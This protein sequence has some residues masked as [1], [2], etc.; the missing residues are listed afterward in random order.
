M[1]ITRELKTIENFTTENRHIHRPLHG[2]R[3][4]L[5]ARTFK[6]DGSDCRVGFAEIRTDSHHVFF[7]FIIRDLR[8]FGPLF[9]VPQ[10]VKLRTAILILGAGNDKIT[11]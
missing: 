3:K 9:M 5:H 1:E 11:V 6:H 10:V 7:C 4:W 8:T 2:S